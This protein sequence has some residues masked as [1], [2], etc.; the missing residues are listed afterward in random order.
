MN[1]L[2]LAYAISTRESSLQKGNHVMKSQKLFPST[3]N[4]QSCDLSRDTCGYKTAVPIANNFYPGISNT[5]STLTFFKTLQ[6]DSD[7]DF[8]GYS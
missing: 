7:N 2:V 1:G 3:E 5:Q 6:R 8:L 4:V